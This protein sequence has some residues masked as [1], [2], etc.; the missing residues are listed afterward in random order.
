MKTFTY[1]AR[2]QEFG[3]IH[4]GVQEANTKDEAI[5]QLKEQ[6]LI[7]SKIEEV[8][9]QHD[10]DLRIGSRH[11]KDE[12][13]AI[14]CNQFAIILRAG[15]PIVHTI[16]LISDQTEDK[17]LKKILKDVSDEVSAGHGLAASFE[18]YGNGLPTTFI[19]TVRAGEDSGNLDTVF[20]RLSSYYEKS[21]KS[22][23]KVKSAMIYPTFVLVVAVVVVAVIMVFAVPTF[24]TTFESMNIELPLPTLI[25]IATSDFMVQW[26]LVII[27]VIVACVV[28]V[29]VLKRQSEAFHLRWSE[30]GTKI[31][32]VGK[33]N[34]MNNAAQYASTMSIMMTAGLPI[35]QAV[36]I[37]S[38]TL[39]NYFMAHALA[40]TE[41]ALESGKPLAES[42]SK[43]QAF[44]ELVVEMTGVGEDTGTL[45]GT[46]E[47]IADYYDS[48]VEKNTSR[49]VSLLE[50]ITIVILAG[51]VVMVL[52]A[53]YLPMFSLYSNY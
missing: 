2:H 23:N 44:P 6:G 46:L 34:V 24:K 30:W 15:L 4:E 48:E 26:F 41:P 31:P 27:A 13:L 22:K 33:I 14:M 16:R 32:V 45:E 20:E 40:S 50:P 36:D 39:S 29:K 5:A 53:V 25:M 38:K 18:K 37:T 49:A 42:L 7:V 11:A 21:A 47:V 1:T 9:T 17:T 8:Q 10:L 12:S 19:E 3:D 51:I 43:T 52:L 28:A 35:V